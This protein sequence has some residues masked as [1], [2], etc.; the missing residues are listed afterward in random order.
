MKIRVLF[1]TAFFTVFILSSCS[2]LSP[3][4][5]LSESTYVINATS[6]HIMT[7][8][9][10]RITLMVLE[11]EANPAYNTTQMAYTVKPYKIDYFAQN[12][13]ANAPA[14]MLQALIVQSLQN[15]HYFHAVVEPPFIGRYDYALSTKILRLEQDFT[16]HRPILHLIVQ[17]QLT[18]VSNNRVIA[19]E[20]FSLH[21][22]MRQVTPY[23][24]VVATNIASAE[25]LREL[26]MF[27]LKNT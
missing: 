27:C 20:V 14:Q 8:R 16:Y 2:L 26:T 23:A 19:T 4:K 24:G 22:A 17:A 18:R 13:W 25:F 1:F 3:V 7:K 9:P 5:P 6:D 21:Q 15:T 12:R 11:T 10:K